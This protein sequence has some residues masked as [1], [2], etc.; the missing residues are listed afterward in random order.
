LVTAASLTVSQVESYAVIVAAALGVDR[1]RLT[2]SLSQLVQSAAARRLLATEVTIYIAVEATSQQNAIALSAQIST[3]TFLYNVNLACQLQGLAS[4]IVDATTLTYV[5]VDAPPSSPP[6]ATPSPPNPSP[7]SPT[8]SPPSPS[9]GSPP[10]PPPPPGIDVGGGGK[11][12]SGESSQPP[13]VLLAFF[14]L[15]ALA[16]ILP[17]QEDYD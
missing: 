16:Y 3:S 5:N 9:P 14:C 13:A 4:A 11:S 2:V 1:G 7:P 17:H 15:F 12:E 6:S 10:S 8:P